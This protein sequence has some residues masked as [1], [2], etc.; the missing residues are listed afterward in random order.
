MRLLLIPIAAL[1]LG[2]PASAQ[3]HRGDR[4][5]DPLE[6]D[7]VRAIPPAEEIEAMAPALDRALSALLSVDVGPILDA[8]DPARRRYDHGRPGR[9]LGRI[10][11]HGDPRFEERMRGSVYRSTEDIA[12]MSGAFAAA[13]P[14]LARS[15]RDLQAALAAANAD[16]HRRGPGRDWDRDVDRDVDRDLDRDHDLDRDEDVD[17]DRDA[18]PDGGPGPEDDRGPDR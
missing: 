2:A 4:R 12:R 15:L 6:R 7:I 17:A 5:V 10:G 13:A 3:D 11:S 8:A 14:S 1:A 18:Y 9:T 16:Y